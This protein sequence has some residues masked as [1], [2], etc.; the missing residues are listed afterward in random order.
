MASEEAGQSGH[1][2]GTFVQG[3][4]LVDFAKLVNDNFT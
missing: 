1:K 2:I 3:L 4:A